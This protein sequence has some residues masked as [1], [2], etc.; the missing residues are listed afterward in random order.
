MGDEIFDEPGVSP[1]GFGLDPNIL[2]VRA[3][4]NDRAAI[5]K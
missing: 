3:Q 4:H 1:L 2:Y 5:L